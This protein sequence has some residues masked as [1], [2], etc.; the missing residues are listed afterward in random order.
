MPHTD[1]P[2]A[3]DDISALLNAQWNNYTGHIPEPQWIVASDPNQ[4]IRIELLNAGDAVIIRL[5]TPGLE[6]RP[7][8]T[9]VYGNRTSRVLLEI[10]TVISRQRLY[11]LMREI[12]RIC[13]SQMHSMTNFQRLQFVSFNELTQTTAQF[14]SGRCILEVVNFSIL[15]E[16]T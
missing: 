8:G 14:W 3:A 15:L 7:I 6:E 10:A 16:V 4:P 12:R 2:I 11:N 1:E 9:W 13:H 5:D